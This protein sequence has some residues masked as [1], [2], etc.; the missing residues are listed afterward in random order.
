LKN[1]VHLISESAIYFCTMRI[2]IFLFIHSII[3]SSCRLFKKKDNVNKDVVV[4]V[5]DKYLYKDDLSDVFKSGTLKQDSA[6]TV[7][8]YVDNWIHQQ[9]V[10][11]K[12][13]A[14]LDAEKKD[15][16]KQLEEYRNS[17]VRYAYE[18]ELIQQKLD[19]NVTDVEIESFYNSNPDNFQLKKNILKVIY[20]KLNKKSPKLGKVRDLY[21]SDNSKDRAWIT[22]YCRQ[23]AMNYYLDDN[24]WLQFDDLLKEIPIK[25]YD[26]EQFLQN[27]RNIEVEDSTNIYLISIKGFRIKNSLSPLSFEKSSIRTMLINQRKLKLIADMEKQAY[28][29]AKDKSE[30]QIMQNEK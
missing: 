28:E 20:L 24:A 14:N 12:A 25:T 10:M 27:N 30:I 8:A 9:V 15:V 21:K 2:V 6:T 26:Q 23:Y 5:Y 11:H 18:R 13:E 29:E 22:D 4:R 17:L 1:G 19:T 7:K 3:I 16:E